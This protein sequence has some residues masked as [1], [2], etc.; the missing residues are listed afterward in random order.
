MISGGHLLVRCLE[1]QGVDRV[2]FVP[3]E[4]FLDVLDGLHDSPFRTIVARQEGG[5]AIMHI[6]A[7]PETITPNASLSKIRQLTHKPR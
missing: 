2:F 1:A 7:D 3:G 6:K 4:S 5:A